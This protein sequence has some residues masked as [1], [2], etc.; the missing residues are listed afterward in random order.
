[1]P[2]IATA[3]HLAILSAVRGIDRAKLVRDESSRHN[4]DFGAVGPGSIVTVEGTPCLVKSVSTYA[5][6]NWTFKKDLKYAVREWELFSLVSGETLWLEWERDDEVVVFLSERKLP[7]NPEKYGA[8][9]WKT[10]LDE[11][12]LSG[13]LKVP[14]EG[15]T[16]AYDDEGSW[17]AEYFRGGK[18]EAALVRFYEFVSNSGRSLTIEAWMSP[19]ERRFDLK[20][21]EIDVWLSRK[22][23]PTSVTLLAGS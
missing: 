1:M 3:K 19:G 9:S 8:A 21:A 23:F 18:D 5:E 17:A 2:T 11:D 14:A 6:K 4:V 16:F 15:E 13:S 7:G 20:D 12:R 10:F 22:I